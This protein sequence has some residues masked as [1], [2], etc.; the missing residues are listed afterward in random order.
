MSFY[1]EMALTAV[2]M[3]SEFGQPVIITRL[4]LGTPDLNTG[5]VPQIITTA[6]GTGV[7]LDF[8]YRNFGESLE[9]P[10]EITK[11]TKR[12]LLTVNVPVHAKDQ[13]MVDGNVYQIIVAKLVNPAGIRILYDL[14]IEQ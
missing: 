9:A 8:L 12:L 4:E 10:D 5:V 7:L 2:Q 13:V 11:S 1:S 3:L 14:W 6:I